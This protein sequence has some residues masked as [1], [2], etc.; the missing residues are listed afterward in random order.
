MPVSLILISLFFCGRRCW[1]LVLLSS[2][3]ETRKPTL[4]LLWVW[5]WVEPSLAFLF[6]NLARIRQFPCETLSACNI[7]ISHSGPGLPGYCQSAR[8]AT[9]VAQLHTHN[10]PLLPTS[11]PVG[12]LHVRSWPPGVKLTHW[13][14]TW[15]LAG[16]NHLIE[17]GRVIQEERKWWVLLQLQLIFE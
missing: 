15:L 7:V 14:R 9:P 8:P 12:P 1:R 10:H 4:W 17:A 16:S 13:E 5:G 6:P 2:V 3:W 11:R